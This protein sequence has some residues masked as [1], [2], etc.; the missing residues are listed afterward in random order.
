MVILTELAKKVNLELQQRLKIQ[1]NQSELKTTLH[2][3]SSRLEVAEEQIWE[4]G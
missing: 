2:G 4:A 1:N 3:I